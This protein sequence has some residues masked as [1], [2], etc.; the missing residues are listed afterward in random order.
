MLIT[1]DR[2]ASPYHISAPD[3]KSLGEAWKLGLLTHRMNTTVQGKLVDCEPR[4]LC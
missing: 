4:Q 3:Q 1:Q 2:Y